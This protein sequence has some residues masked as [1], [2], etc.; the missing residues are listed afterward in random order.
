MY[1]AKAEFSFRNSKKQYNFI[2]KCSLKV[3]LVL[4]FIDF[5]KNGTILNS[6]ILD[7]WAILLINKMLKLIIF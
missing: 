2:K 4:N 7:I 1:R 5:D 6:S 3:R